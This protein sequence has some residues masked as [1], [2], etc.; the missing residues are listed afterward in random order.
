MVIARN[1]VGTVLRV[2]GADFLDG[3]VQ[4]LGDLCEMDATVHTHGVGDERLAGQR[5]ADVVLLVVGH[6]IV[7]GDE[8]GDIATRLP[9]QVLIDVPE[10]TCAA[11]AVQGLVDVAWAA[12]IGGNGQRPVVIDLIQVLEVLG[13][14]GA[15]AIGVT[16][17]VHE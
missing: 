6:R 7:G 17:L 2:E 13:C 10:V 8:C 11:I 15:G 5:R 16:A 3:D 4:H 9:G 14:H 1:H 12:V